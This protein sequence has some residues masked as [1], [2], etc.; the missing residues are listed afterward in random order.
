MVAFFFIP[1]RSQE[2]RTSA[3]CLFRHQPLAMYRTWTPWMTMLR[4]L[5]YVQTKFAQVHVHPCSHNDR[6]QGG[7]SVRLRITA[8]VSDSFIHPYDS[9]GLHESSIVS[10]LIG[11]CSWF[12]C[13]F[14]HSLL[15]SFF[16]S[17]LHSFIHLCI[18]LFIHSC[19]YSVTRSLILSFIYPSMHPLNQSLHHAFTH[20]LWSATNG[21]YIPL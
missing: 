4:Q 8:C 12:M 14:V 21:V 19:I 16:H 5:K 9:H 11:S 7:T 6:Q 10:L 1:S 18:H 3:S 15:D 17:F 13:T 20:L 2:R